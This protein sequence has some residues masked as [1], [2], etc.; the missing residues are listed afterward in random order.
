MLLAYSEYLM[1]STTML[2]GN[3]SEMINVYHGHSYVR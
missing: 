2:L 3:V 1:E